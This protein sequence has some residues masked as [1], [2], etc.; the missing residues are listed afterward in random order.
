MPPNYYY[1]VATLTRQAW[2]MEQERL[3]DIRSAFGLAPTSQDEEWAI[4]CSNDGEL[5]ELV[6]SHLDQLIDS[7]GSRYTVG[8]FDGPVQDLLTWT[9]CDQQIRSLGNLS[10]A[11]LD[12]GFDRPFTNT[13]RLAVAAHALAHFIAESGRNV[14]ESD[15]HSGKAPRLSK[16]EARDAL[17]DKAANNEP[18]GSYQEIGAKIG[19]SKTTASEI[20]NENEGLRKWYD[21]CRK[22]TGNKMKTAFRQTLSAAGMDARTSRLQSR[23][24]DPHDAAVRQEQREHL[25]QTLAGDSVLRAAAATPEQY[26]DRSGERSPDRSVTK[27]P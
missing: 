10:E 21:E 15:G 7:N 16:K 22:R 12:P 17:F 13:Y 24:D 9:K 19:C 5:L 14:S 4:F 11:H 1:L 25:T 3:S 6:E 23:E 2:E 26:S 20:I 8:R 18:F 27:K